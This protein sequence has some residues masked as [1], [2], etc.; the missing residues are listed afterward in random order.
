MFDTFVSF[1]DTIESDIAHIVFNAWHLGKV[2]KLLLM[3]SDY[4]FETH[5]VGGNRL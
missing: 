2:T 4:S 3:R 5:I 1:Y